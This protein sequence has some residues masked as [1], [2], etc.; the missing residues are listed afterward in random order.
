MKA[1]RMGAASLWHWLTIPAAVPALVASV[2]RSA[3]VS[4]GSA[5]VITGV[6]VIANA[7]VNTAHENLVMFNPEFCFAFVVTAWRAGRAGA[8]IPYGKR[9]LRS[10]A[11]GPHTASRLIEYAAPQRSNV[12][13]AY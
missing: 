10:N 1:A 3:A 7:R 11:A 9:I 13:A 5:M 12:S 8:C 4:W 6:N 2:A